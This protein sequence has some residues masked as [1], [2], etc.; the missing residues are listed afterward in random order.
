MVEKPSC[1]I[2][3]LAPKASFDTVHAAACGEDAVDWALAA[4]TEQEACTLSFAAVD[5]AEHLSRVAGIEALAMDVWRRKQS[6]G[7][8]TSRGPVRQPHRRPLDP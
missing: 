3:V 5:A 7:Q 2:V 6:S 4:S 8:H 1:P